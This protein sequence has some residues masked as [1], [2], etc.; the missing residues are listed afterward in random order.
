MKRRDWLAAAASVGAAPGLRAASR[1]AAPAGTL[2]VTI[3]AP[4]TGFDPTQI[5]DQNSARIAALIFDAPLDYDYVARPARLVPNT[6]VA[7][8][9]ISSDFRTFTFTLRPGI[10]FAD[11][12]AFKGRRREL[13]AA[14]YVYSIKRY[15][16]PR[17]KSE[18]LYIWENAQ[19]LGLSELRKE[20]IE[21]KKP[22]DYDR[23]VE[24][25]RALDRYT[26]RVRLAA[27]DPRF[28]YNF[29]G[30]AS[31][32][33]LAREVVD[34]YGDDIASH[35]V[36][37]GAYRLGPWQRGS[38]ITLERNPNYRERRF[39]GVPAEGDATAQRIAAELAGARLPVADR[40]EIHVIEESQP[41]YLAF[42]GGELDLLRVPLDFAAVAAPGGKL[43]PNLA[44]RGVRMQAAPQ[45]D[46]TMTYFNMEHP[47]VGG[48]AP[49]KVALRRAVALAFDST[50]E[51]RL[52]MNHQGVLAQSVVPPFTS[53]YD[54]AYRSEMSEHSPA[55]AKALLDLYGYVDRDGDGW[56][57]NPDGSPLTLRLASLANQL[58]RR[59]N[60]LWR[61]HMAAVG[62]RMEFDVGTWGDLLKRS[63]AGSLM[64]WGFSWAA[65]SPDSSFFLGMAYGPNAGGSNDS[66]FALPAYDRL[67]EQQRRLPDGPE[68]FAL[69]RK[70][71]NLLVAQM[72]YKVRMHNLW[73]DLLQPRVRGFWRHPFL[74]DEWMYAGVDAES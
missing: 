53:A 23:E 51:L 60:E 36:G 37:T 62:L 59:R 25:I 3:N 35:P 44:R 8:P 10:F 49:E 67:F 4:E 64:M 6:A 17:L 43:A 27:P 24:G 19:L 33:A 14:D 38:K 57:E 11:D 7:L 5:G 12:P 30:N 70:A 72:P 74:R 22:F 61:K 50:E 40:I 9:E 29:A 71:K 16:D 73:I 41:Q 2:R 39:D 58:E 68:R 63:L 18:N 55:R 56:R 31:A 13:T 1:G 65:G 54:P 20:A 42:A 34:A 21:T 15:Y 26:F 52:V 69:M 32:P 28:H 66:R 48:Y 45:A 47:V 46:I